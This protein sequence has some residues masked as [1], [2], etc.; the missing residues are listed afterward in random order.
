[1]KNKIILLLLIF[2]FQIKIGKSQVLAN[3]TW[4]VY[5]SSSVFFYYFHFD[6]DTLSFSSDDI[7]YTNVSLYE[8]SGANFKIYDLSGFC[9]T[10]TGRYT[11]SMMSDTLDFN[12]IIDTCD[13]SRA[14]VF[15][16]YYWIG[17]GIGINSPEKNQG[18][19]LYPNPANDKITLLNW[20][21]G[22]LLIYNSFGQ[23]VRTVS[24]GREERIL[25][26]SN[27]SNGIYTLV[28]GSATRK[29]IVSR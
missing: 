22:D 28:N 24:L 19:N 25:D 10:D 4:Q 9:M 17:M 21:Q 11:F 16:T 12:L 23:L 18:F 29:L 3:T 20:G 7:Y 5:T 13:P 14:T 8:E 15:D 1:M 26:I 2:L 27:L 6:G